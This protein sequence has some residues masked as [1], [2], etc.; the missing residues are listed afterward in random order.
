MPLATDRE[1]IVTDFPP[2]RFALTAIYDNILY[3]SISYAAPISVMSDKHSGAI[4]PRYINDA[5]T[6]LSLNFENR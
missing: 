2:P 1:L 6:G 4:S 3:L 5:N